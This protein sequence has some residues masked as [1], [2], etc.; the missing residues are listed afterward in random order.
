MVKDAVMS[1]LPAPV[2]ELLNS[3]GGAIT[4][5]G[6]LA[7]GLLAV[8]FGLV[9]SNYVLI[10]GLW[11]MYELYHI[12]KLIEGGD[13]TQYIE[14]WKGELRLILAIGNIILAIART[15]VALIK[16]W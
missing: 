5:F 7:F 2:R 11:G 8:L 3:V 9:T 1:V 13:F 15:I 6:G 14:H 12:V 4:G 16:W 10:L